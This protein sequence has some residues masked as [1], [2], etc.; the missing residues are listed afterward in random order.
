VR[1]VSDIQTVGQLHEK[2]DNVKAEVMAEAEK[3]ASINDSLWLYRGQSRCFPAGQ[4]LLPKI[5]RAWTWGTSAG[6]GIADVETYCKDTERQISQEFKRMARDCKPALTVL[7]ATQL[8]WLAL[9]QHH[10]L[11]TRLLDWT[12]NLR[13]ALWFA[14]WGDNPRPT[15]WMSPVDQQDK[16]T[17][18]DDQWWVR[19]AREKVKAE[20]PDERHE[21]KCVYEVRGHANRTLFF[22]PDEEVS[23]RIKAQEGWLGLFPDRRGGRDGPQ[24]SLETN[25]RYKH[26]IA[27]FRLDSRRR[28][29]LQKELL[30]EK[31]DTS[32]RRLFPDL[33]GLS[34]HLHLRHL[35]LGLEAEG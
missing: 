20:N 33:D 9:A 3:D 2:I 15:V 7:P 35:R 32:Q 22:E 34:K 29:E 8:D 25:G 12:E 10:G 21:V 18:D 23:P 17:R 28:A 26:K 5:Y 4:E 31:H 19:P 24:T 1:G 6:N 27:Y 11:P 16:L 13:T 14:L 30:T